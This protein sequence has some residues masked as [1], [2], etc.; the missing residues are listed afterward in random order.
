MGKQLLV[1]H[2]RRNA[3]GLKDARPYVAGKRRIRPQQSAVCDGPKV[4]TYMARRHPNVNLIEFTIERYGVSFVRLKY[5]DIP[6]IHA[7][8]PHPTQQRCGAPD[9]H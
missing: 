6:L 8:D 7:I 2:A 1:G 9:H 4:I 3:C 5:S